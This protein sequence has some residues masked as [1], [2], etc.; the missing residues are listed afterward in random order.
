[1]KR[2]I[3]LLTSFLITVLACN[4][5]NTY[6]KYHP[7]FIHHIS[8][9][10]AGIIE[11]DAVIRIVLSDSLT[12][13]Q[14]KK[15]SDLDLM[16]FSPNIKGK[17]EMEGN[18]TVVFIPN[19]K[20]PRNMV[21]QAVFNLGKVKKVDRVLRRFPFRF[22][23][24]K[25]SV[26]MEVGALQAYSDY[27]P[28]YRHIEGVL[29]INDNEEIDALKG[30][31]SAD[32]DGKNLPVK[33]FSADHN[34]QFIFRIDSILR[35]EKNRNLTIRLNGKSIGASEVQTE[36][37]EVH[38]LGEFTLTNV[39]IQNE[40]DQK[41]EAVFS[42]AISVMQSIDGMIW[43][44]EDADIN[45]EINGN[46]VRIF[47]KNRLTGSH[48]IKFSKSIQNNMGYNLKNETIREIYFDQ[49]KP[50]L[51]LVGNGTI[52]PDAKGVVFPFEAMALKAVD[53]W[54]Y[55][56]YEKN[57]PQFL[58]VNDLEESGQL[59][60]VGK[61]IH[62]SK[63]D[64]S[65]NKKV[66]ENEWTRY[67]L[68]LGKF[69]NQEPGAIYRVMIGFRKSYTFFQCEENE[70]DYQ[71]DADP[72]YY[73]YY[74]NSEY[75]LREYEPCNSSFYYSGAIARNILASDLGLMVKQGSDQ[76]FH[77]FTTDL[78][79]AKPKAGVKVEL[80][81]YQNTRMASAVSDENGMAVFSSKEEDPYLL[82]GSSGKQKGYLKLGNGRSNSTSKF[83]VEG[84]ND[85]KGI[86]GIIYTERGVW[87]PGDSMYV[88]FILQDKLKNL[89]SNV[90]VN[91]TLTDPMGKNLIQ[92]V[93]NQSTGGIYD[94]RTATPADAITGT[95]RAKVEV[96]GNTF[97][98]SL[99]VETVQPNRLKI[100]M[101]VSDSA[102]QLKG[103]DTIYLKTRWLHGAPSP[104]LAYQVNARI[105]S[106]TTRFKGF[107]KYSFDDGTKS[108]NQMERVAA[109]GKL[110][111]EGETHFSPNWSFN[112]NAPGRLKVDFIAKVFEKSGNFSTDF[113]E[114]EI[115]PYASYVGI[116]S[117]SSLQ[118]DGS[119]ETDKSHIFPL[120]HLKANGKPAND[121][122]LQV[123]I[124][125]LDWSWWWESDRNLSSYVQSHSI[126]PMMDSLVK[127]ANGKGKVSFRIPYPNWGQ[128]LMVAKD[129]VSG[130]TT[131]KVF[132]IDWPYWRR[133]NRNQTDDASII[134]LS[135]GKSHYNV[136]Q[137]MQITIPATGD[138]MALVCVENGSSVLK[139]FWVNTTKGETR[140]TVTA[141][142]EMS[143][144]AY[145]HVSYLQPYKQTDNDLPGRMYGIIPVMV[146]NPGS[147]ISPVLN[148]PDEIRPDVAQR[149]VVSESNGNPMTYTLAV[150]DEG[151]LDLTHF[152]TPEVWKHFNQKRGLGVRTWDL[153]DDV[154]GGYAGK[155]SNVLSVG[156]DEEG[157]NAGDATH[158][159]NRFKPAIR[160]IGPFTIPAN[161]KAVH[162]IKMGDYIGAVRVMVVARNGNAY[163]TT[164]KSVKV[165]KPLMVL[166]TLPRI[167]TPGE[168]IVIPVTVFN[169]DE[170]AKKVMVKISAKGNLELKGEATKTIEF[171]RA[172]DEI[173][174]FLATVK[175]SVGLAEVITSVTDGVETASAETELDVRAPNPVVTHVD[176]YVIKPGETLDIK[177]AMQGIDGTND[178]SMEVSG[179]PPINLAQ[180]L[181]ELIHYPH[182]CVEQTTS[183]VFAQL[184]LDD[185]M[186]LNEER[187]NEVNHNIRAAINRLRS[188]QTGDGGLA[189]WPGNSE[190]NEWGS[191]YAG[192]FLTAAKA[193][194]Y[195]VNEYF[196]NRWIDYQ[197][198]K[199]RQYSSGIWYDQHTQAYRL[200]TLALAGKPE[201]SAMN[202]LR[203]Q[204]NLSNEARWRLAAAY[205]LAGLPESAKALI[206][207]VSKV[208][209]SYQ[210]H[211]NTYGSSL[212]DQAMILETMVLMKKEDEGLKL[213]KEISSSLSK[214]YWLS[215]QETAYSLIAIAGYHKKYK[216]SNGISFTFTEKGRAHSVKSAK[217]FVQ[218]QLA[219]KAKRSVEA[220]TVSNKGEGVL[221]VRVIR[222]G[223]PLQG[224]T[225]TISRNLNLKIKYADL[226]G[227][228][229]DPK[230]IRQGTEFRMIVEIKNPGTKGYQ[231]DMA[232][233][234]LIPGGWE[235]RNE[236]MFGNGN[237]QNYTYRDYK[238]DRVYTYF[239]LG[240]GSQTTY[241][242]LLTATYQGTFYQPAVVAENMYDHEV[243]AS[244][245]GRW[246]EVKPA[247]YG[248]VN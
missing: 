226:E 148:I 50:K 86:D 210:S 56:V 100:A 4:R 202:R 219:Q 225:N 28:K 122:K 149:V 82:V 10:T 97:Y 135:T 228:E 172:G 113:S 33:V 40:P 128:F 140:F 213:L 80:F 215:T 91:F 223:V 136:G 63:V 89:P 177:A 132:Y 3:F 36:I 141:T 78:I 76:K 187:V 127:T 211:G 179:M 206:Q 220:T 96:G 104:G 224:D 13:R 30:C 142:E 164:E 121:G 203:E 68:N 67:T 143:P 199:S 231:A 201:L 95:Y 240:A 144:N 45:Y 205:V 188:F 192:H 29:T 162:N 170:K 218:M 123:K 43:L 66:A 217:P 14:I 48:E 84:I 18:R 41:I 27:D 176:E 204:Q 168:K 151:L 230:T 75:Y 248:R 37:V 46:V 150:V 134:Q 12:Q 152:K 235:I 184:F 245:P 51:R 65:Q 163:G 189:Y 244:L 87:R 73:N 183:S 186:I 159:A 55:Q 19:E 195:E 118:E 155:W 191:N 145:V 101:D 103:K 131:S 94:F 207:D 115:S 5:S 108:F 70:D 22:E 99:P 114:F 69:I 64:L 182:G 31:I 21:Y 7:D 130:H 227:R 216:A 200:Y 212:R 57:I 71:T 35:T 247:E 102:L 60:R 236:R 24:P 229:L 234:Q 137:N 214:A 165:K 185:F 88:M 221:F 17:Y 156:G 146:E 147:H 171:S 8:A 72:L 62:T 32:L 34:K 157:S 194:G 111:E 6:P 59:K 124:Y 242:V 54:I 161:G 241:E 85:E 190:S 53:V 119:M 129:P 38:G 90:P 116:G 139:K 154:L 166:N 125:R 239:N 26:N 222:A 243:I 112:E 126:I 246:V 109:E 232:L 175:E 9:Y 193:R 16:E 25:Q 23:T 167:L 174:T 106:V 11:R 181:D 158:K 49:T 15:L 20:L 198:N 92:T 47:P 133:V 2:S 107:E 209:R 44:D 196:Y 237:V 1:M 238:D 93:K 208:S 169:L 138:G 160:F 180:R 39:L 178:A 110:D 61:L 42:D 233:S 98:R 105:R 120:A 74:S 77:V 173:V 79:T 153:Y 117:P 58:Q 83:D 52:V 197:T 81:D